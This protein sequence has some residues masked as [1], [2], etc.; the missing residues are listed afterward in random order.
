MRNRVVPPVKHRRAIHQYQKWLL[1]KINCT[2]TSY[3]VTPAI[4]RL[5]SPISIGYT[6]VKHDVFSLLAGQPVAFTMPSSDKYPSDLAPMCRQISSTLILE[7]I[8]SSG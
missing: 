1:H 7:A 6:P 4:C 3:L 8:S 2:L 5:C